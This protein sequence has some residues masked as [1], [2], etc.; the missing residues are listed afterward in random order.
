M[1][2]QQQKKWRNYSQKILQIPDN[3]KASD[4]NNEEY[5][6]MARELR[7]AQQRLDAYAQKVPEIPS[8]QKAWDRKYAGDPNV[9]KPKT[10]AEKQ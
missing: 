6:D 4:I 8:E 3:T 7:S 5:A 2:F 9:S 1:L 10:I